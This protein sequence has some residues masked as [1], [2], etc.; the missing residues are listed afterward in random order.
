MRSGQLEKQFNSKRQENF[1]RSI[2]GIGDILVFETR[3]QNNS[4]VSAGLVDLTGLTREMLDL[5]LKDENAFFSLF[6]SKSFV[7]SY[8]E[9]RNGVTLAL[10]FYREVYQ[11]GLSTPINQISRVYKEAIDCRNEAITALCVR[12][13][14][15][16]LVQLSST[17]DNEAFTGPILRGLA[18]FANRAIEHGDPSAEASA[19]GWYFESV[20]QYSEEEETEFD[21]D[22]IGTFD[23][24]LFGRL[25]K[26][27]LE[28]KIDLTGKFINECVNKINWLWSLEGNK[29]SH[30][31]VMQAIGRIATASTSAYRQVVDLL[32]QLSSNRSE[33][34]TKEKC[35]KWRDEWD[36]SVSLLL[37]FLNNDEKKKLQDLARQCRAYA[38]GIFK[39]NILIQLSFRMGAFC[40]YKNRPNHIGRMWEIASHDAFSDFSP[41]EFEIVPTTLQGTVELYFARQLSGRTVDFSEDFSG[42]DD[43]FREYFLILLM[44]SLKSVPFG[45]DA[46]NNLVNTFTLPEYDPYVL[47]HI[48]QIATPLASLANNMAEKIPWLGNLLRESD[49]SSFINTE[50]KPFLDRIQKESVRILEEYEQKPVSKIKVD[51]F[52]NQVWEAYNKRVSMRVLFETCPGHFEDSTSEIASSESGALQIFT[53]D[54]IS[55]KAPFLEHWFADYPMWGST[56]GDY[57]AELEE[58]NLL[59]RL[60]NECTHVKM[61]DVDSSIKSF[62]TPQNCIL[63]FTRA[64]QFD[65]IRF[66]SQKDP[67]FEGSIRYLKDSTK[68]K[69]KIADYILANM[70]IPIY[71]ANLPMK[72]RSVLVLNADHLGT[73]VQYSP[74]NN[75]DKEGDLKNHILIRVRGFSEHPQLLE[76]YLSS[77][78]LWV[79]GPSNVEDRKRELLKSVLIEIRERFKYKQAENFK[80]FVV[81]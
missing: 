66:I 61:E 67:R 37:P 35:K 17:K 26:I 75:D 23:D 62:G 39:A 80:G 25:C 1:I 10:P 43:F 2:E 76:K 59:L 71:L 24:Y 18:E 3:R 5:R 64:A 65:Y 45:P 54:S 55:E 9:D 72:D 73:L 33:L 58:M 46:I 20:F 41:S 29:V 44:R 68:R 57:L 8:K 81:I 53:H 19:F 78:T 34:N 77:P 42:S 38:S 30:L 11:I 32:D 7:D 36:R 49:I 56:E 6:F 27:V 51:A 12:H 15:D 48:N 69:G 52:K 21:I 74:L 22:S 31:Q 16:V 40:V 79:S 50:L 63:I 28:D 4:I 47:Y 14:S 60:R 13:L 70:P